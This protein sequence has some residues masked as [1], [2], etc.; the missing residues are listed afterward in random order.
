MNLMRMISQLVMCAVIFNG[1]GGS[2][3]CQAAGATADPAQASAAEIRRIGT[4]NEAL[5][6]IT[7]RD[8]R[9]LKG[10]VIE[11]KQAEFVIADHK[12]GHTSIVEYAQVS[13]L[14]HRKKRQLSDGARTAIV[15]GIAAGIVTLAVVGYII[16][17]RPKHSG[18]TT[19]P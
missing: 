18:K 19:F 15:V 10:Y 2:R 14:K 9:K 13:Q 6:E 4:G 17:Q 3:L 8:G 11:I 1:S 5:V 12:T 7:L 16:G